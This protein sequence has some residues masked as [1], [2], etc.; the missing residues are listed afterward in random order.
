MK[1]DVWAKA[2]SFIASMLLLLSCTVESPGDKDN[3][4]SSGNQQQVTNYS[5]SAALHT[6]SAGSGVIDLELSTKEGNY[7]AGTEI[8]VKATAD[9]N[10]LFAGWYSSNSAYGYT[11]ST[12]TI[13]TFKLESDT[14]LFAR[15]DIAPNFVSGIT[16]D[17]TGVGYTNGTQMT[18][19]YK[20]GDKITLQA[21]PSSGSFFLGWYD[22]SSEGHLISRSNPY[23]HTFTKKG[24]V[25]ARFE[26]VYI[27]FKDKVLENAIRA[28]IKKPE[29]KITFTDIKN[30]T[31][32][33]YHGYNNPKIK[34]LDDLDYFP[35]L[36]SL[37]LIS[38]ELKDISKMKNLKKLTSLHL[39]NN[40]LVDISVL[41]NLPHISQL[42]LQDNLIADITPLKYLDFKQLSS[43]KL[44]G[45]LISDISIINELPDN[46]YIDL[47]NNLITE[48]PVFRENIGF[49]SLNL[50]KNEIKDI[51]TLKSINFITLD[52]TNTGVVDIQPLIDNPHIGGHSTIKINRSTIDFRQINQLNAKGVS[53]Q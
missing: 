46:L 14:R 20:V 36:T 10:S 16:T 8:T 39:I 34:S 28:Q 45:N 12:S 4:N 22:A 50:S 53:V 40:L 9:S 13:Y 44:S 17:S 41:K 3:Q 29:G 48:L 31:S 5:Y 47:S 52:L 1:K 43:L 24:E 49:M 11:L 21:T 6:G 19:L 15:F 33:N 51:S 30:I 18:G 27:T 26:D 7:P 25:H 32:L 37:S 2:L 35:S 38:S 42:E 23:T